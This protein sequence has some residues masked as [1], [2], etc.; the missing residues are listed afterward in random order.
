MPHLARGVQRVGVDHDQPGTQRTEHGNRIMQDVGHLYRDAIARHQIGLALQ[1]TGEGCAVAFQV[2]VGQGHPH[3]T[4]RWTVGE[5]LAGTLE[6]L[7]HRL[8]AT[9]IDIDGYAGRAFIIPEIRL[10]YSCP[11]YLSESVPPL[12]DVE[13]RSFWDT[14]SYGDSGKYKH[15]CH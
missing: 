7:D 5:L 9:Q 2:S 12:C 3:V 15:E 11:L 13:K 14:S 4:E 6:H 1:I 10:H 8:V